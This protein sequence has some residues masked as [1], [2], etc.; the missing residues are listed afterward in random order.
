MFKLFKT[1]ETTYEVPIGI[2]ETNK[3]LRTKLDGFLH[4]QL[5]DI[6]TE[7]FRY[8]VTYKVQLTAI[9]KKETSSFLG[10][11]L[12]N[13][14]YLRNYRLSVVMF[15]E[16]V[17]IKVLPDGQSAPP[18]TVHNK[19]DENFACIS[20]IKGENK[21]LHPIDME[22]VSYPTNLKDFEHKTVEVEKIPLYF[23]KVR[24]V[25]RNSSTQIAHREVILPTILEQ[26]LETLKRQLAFQ[27]Q[28]EYRTGALVSKLSMGRIE[29]S[30]LVSCVSELL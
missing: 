9:H 3:I 28:R 29:M 10:I 30:P 21:S 2:E 17:S 12:S 18:I 20:F 8:A 14:D 6:V 13:K 19:N 27:I 1:Q 22:I 11:K 16:P 26:M 24:Y 15:G 5:P 4:S 25:I 7:D 23:N